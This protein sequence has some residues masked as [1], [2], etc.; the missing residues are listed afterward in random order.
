M[1]RLR[2]QMHYFLPSIAF[3]NDFEEINWVFNFSILKLSSILLQIA[4]W[5]WSL[6]M[7]NLKYFFYPIKNQSRLMEYA[8]FMKFAINLDFKSVFAQ[9]MLMTYVLENCQIT[10][11]WEG[12]INRHKI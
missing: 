8:I 6:G 3:F 2:H 12:W 11:K 5:N 1:A 7:G 4:E 10:E 9:N